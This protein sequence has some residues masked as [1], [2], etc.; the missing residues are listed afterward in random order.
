MGKELQRV[1]HVNAQ[2]GELIEADVDLSALAEQL[3]AQAQAQG[4]ELTGPDGLLTGLT[5][6]MLQSALEAEL[7][8]HLSYDRYAPAGRGSGNSR[9][10]SSPKTVRTEI[11][12]VT[13][14]VPRAR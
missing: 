6:Q 9:N 14:Q 10:G 7:S 4:I 12:E 1:T 13:V 2:T 3:V 5:R 11:G 8:D